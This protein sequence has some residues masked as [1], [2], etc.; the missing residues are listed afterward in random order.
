MELDM[1]DERTTQVMDALAP[2]DIMVA[3]M[4]DVLTVF[5]ENE[6]IILKIFGKTTVPKI[7]WHF[8]TIFMKSK[9]LSIFCIIDNKLNCIKVFFLNK[10]V[11]FNIIYKFKLYQFRLINII[12][13]VFYQASTHITCLF[14]CGDHDFAFFDQQAN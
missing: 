11:F 3:A 5:G 12:I 4:V 6:P 13:K 9:L 7:Q 14:F 1:V 10:A 8:L 2:I